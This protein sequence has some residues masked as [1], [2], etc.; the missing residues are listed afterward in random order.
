M[1]EDL[2]N[3]S[4]DLLKPGYQRAVL[5][6]PVVVRYRGRQGQL[7]H[8]MVPATFE[9]DFASTP[10][11]FWR[12][13]PRWGWYTPAAVMHDFLYN[14]RPCK[15]AEADWRFFTA[16][17]ILSD[18]LRPTLM[19]WEKGKTREWLKRT[20]GFYLQPAWAWVTRWSFY[21]GVR[22]GGGKHYERET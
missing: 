9:T 5:T 14:T 20:V 10:R 4:V 15:R 18:D 6:A 12:I 8:F 22:I 1:I 3:I 13:W 7:L 17:K 2:H 11:V 19:P 21:L 16:L